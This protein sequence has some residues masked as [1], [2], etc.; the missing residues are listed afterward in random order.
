M[1]FKDM[2]AGL[3]GG[4][5]NALPDAPALKTV[6]QPGLDWR[7]EPTFNLRSARP[8][9]SGMAKYMAAG[10]DRLVADLMALTGSGSG[11]SEVRQSLRVMRIRSRQLAIDNEYVKRFLQ[12]ICNNV[13]GPRGFELQMKIYKQRLKDGAKQL[14][15]DANDTVEQAYAEFSKRGVFTADGRQTRAQFERMAAYALPRDGE[16]IIERLVGRRFGRFGM[17]FQMIDPDLLDET[18]NIGTNGAYPGVGQLPSGNSIR[19]GVEVDAYMRPQA[20][21]FHN[22]HPGDDVVN[23][24]LQRHRRVEADRILHIFLS[25]EMRPGT[26]RG[27]PWIYAALRRMAM[28]GG[29]EEAA[30]VAARQGA[31]KMG[32]YKPPSPMAGA[33]AESLPGADGTP[34]ADEEDEEGNLVEEAEPGTFAVLPAGWD[35]ETYDPAYPND[36]MESFIKAMLRAFA[37]GVGLTYNTLASD[38][39]NVSLSSMRHGANADRDTY[40]AIQG[41]LREGICVPVFEHWLRMGLDLGQI[42]RMPM[43]AFDRLNKPLF[44]TRP[45]RSPDPQK[46]IAANAQAVALGVRS[47]TRICAEAG[48]DWQDILDEL[49]NEEQQAREKGVTLNTAAASAHKTPAVDDA[50]KPAEPGEESTTKPQ[51]AGEDDAAAS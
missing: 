7:R 5:G 12:L 38:Y 42:G 48:E 34:V 23:A 45:W 20:Y 24:P 50:G 10:N 49:A 16:V 43:D 35:F 28:L 30:L 36:K 1:A 21:W 39:E 25:E 11:N 26:T 17:A 29:Y 19:M 51:P 22:V 37:S 2:L 47:R 44:I 40:E 41:L 46:D 13:A 3:F 6:A 8:R 33:P 4:Q 27:V 14:D 32:F 15:R 18:L 9:S 31:S